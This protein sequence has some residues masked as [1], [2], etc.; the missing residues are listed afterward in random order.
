MFGLAQLANHTW[1]YS[2]AGEALALRI[3]DLDEIAKE[4]RLVLP[5]R[6]A[7]PALCVQPEEAAS[8][9]SRIGIVPS[10]CNRPVALWI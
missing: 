9:N 1:F 2:P 6:L 5:V 7:L 10:Q 4:Y 8:G 3:G